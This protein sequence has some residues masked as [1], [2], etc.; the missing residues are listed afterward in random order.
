MSFSDSN[1]VLDYGFWY[2]VNDS[3][4]RLKRMDWET[5]AQGLQ[6]KKLVGQFVMEHYMTNP[7]ALQRKR[8][9]SEM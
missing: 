6:P 8:K 1:P 9:Y 5:K 3:H 2:W 7:Q 4:V